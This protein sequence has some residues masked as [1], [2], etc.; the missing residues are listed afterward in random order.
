M[1]F[2]SFKIVQCTQFEKH[3]LTH[4]V[5]LKLNKTFKNYN[6]FYWENFKLQ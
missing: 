2:G 1:F 6:L 5:I 4:C 3:S